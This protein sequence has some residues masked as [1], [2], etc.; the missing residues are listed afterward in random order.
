[1][2]EPILNKFSEYRISTLDG[3]GTN[4]LYLLEKSGN[5]KSVLKIAMLS[6]NK[7]RTEE[8]CLHIL[9]ESNLVPKL[10]SSKLIENKV[11]LHMEYI[12]GNTLLNTLLENQ[13]ASRS[14]DSLS[15]FSS[16]GKLL[17]A[18]HQIKVVEREILSQISLELPPRKTFIDDDLYR[19][20]LQHITDLNKGIVENLVLIHGDF[21]Y[22][23]VIRD[24]ASRHVVIDWELASIGDP[25]LDLANLLFWAH[26]HFP[27]EANEYCRVFI[28]EYLK[29][30]PCVCSPEI[31]HSFVVFQVWRIIEL[32]TDDFPDHVKSEWNRRLSWVLDNIFL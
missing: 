10:I 20:S 2:N 13:N 9:K 16:L 3:G 15:L 5:H 6:N 14:T 19:R 22:H 17:A 25:R 27:E 26:L 32:V 12:E 29:I 31:M 21:G 4:A 1:M 23:N 18:I 30:N 11:C 8:S 24:I 7:A 28:D